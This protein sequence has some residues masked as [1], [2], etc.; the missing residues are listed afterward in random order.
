MKV[1]RD[2]GVQ[3]WHQKSTGRGKWGERFSEPDVVIKEPEEEK[4]TLSLMARRLECE[5]RNF[6]FSFFFFLGLHP[7]H[8]EI[9]RLG[10]ESKL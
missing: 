5:N 9:S 7:L 8:M 1:R 3:L 6:F 10:A 2:S 4:E